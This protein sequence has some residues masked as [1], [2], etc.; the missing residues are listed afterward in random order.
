MNNKMKAHMYHNMFYDGFLE[1]SWTETLATGLL[2]L[3]T[4]AVVVIIFLLL[5]H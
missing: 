3:G 1:E 4:V 2:M 5:T